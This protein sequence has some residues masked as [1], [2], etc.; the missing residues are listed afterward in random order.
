MV[1]DQFM[2]RPQIPIEVS[3]RMYYGCCENCKNRLANDEAARVGRDPVTGEPV[4]KSSAIIA[5]ETSGRVHY[6][7]SEETLKKFSASAATA[8]R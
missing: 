8:A 4:D 5:Q 2:G 3:G 7:A 1:N 6:F